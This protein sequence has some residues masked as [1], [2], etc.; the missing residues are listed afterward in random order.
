[1]GY[2]KEAIE[3]SRKIIEAISEGGILKTASAEFGLHTRTFAEVIAGDSEM[4]LLYKRAQECRADLDADE[5]VDISEREIDPQ[6]ARNMIDARK[7]RA[8][9][10]H[11]RVYGDRIDV[12]IQ[13]TV[14]IAETLNQARAR[15]V[16]RV[17]QTVL[18]VEI[19]DVPTLDANVDDIFS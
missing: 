17:E 15:L 10:Q 18:D 11:A 1:M 2:G 14:N 7:W 5:I 12:N 8:S 13:G 19:E 16:P 9:K 3:K 4:A 6:R